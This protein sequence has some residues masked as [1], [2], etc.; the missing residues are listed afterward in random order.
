MDS[1]ENPSSFQV[2]SVKVLGE[3]A[4]PDTGHRGREQIDLSSCFNNPTTSEDSF[5]HNGLN[6]IALPMG[7]QFIHVN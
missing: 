7:R 4:F 5:L 2:M 3:R 6:P 1:S